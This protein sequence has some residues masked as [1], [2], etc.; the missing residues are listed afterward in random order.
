MDISYKFV[1]VYFIAGSEF[2]QNFVTEA[3]IIQF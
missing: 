1:N 3:S 2:I